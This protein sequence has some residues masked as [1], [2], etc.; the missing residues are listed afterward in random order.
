MARRLPLGAEVQPGGGAHF[1]VWA[2]KARKLE[3]L[4]DG[5]A[6]ALAAEPAGYF[7]GAVPAAR[8]G[9][10]YRFRI[11]RER[12]YPDPASR[13]QPQGP[14]GPSRIID[15]TTFAWTDGAWRGAT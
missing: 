13:S 14:H 4:V 9:S 3:V 15:P 8:A 5:G 11:D 12:D 2:P 10:L 1:R 7:S 6:H